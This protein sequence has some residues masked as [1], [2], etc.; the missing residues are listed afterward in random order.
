MSFQPIIPTSGLVGWKFLERTQEAQL[1]AFSNS[2]AVVT[3]TKYFE[4][5]IGKVN[6]PED[7]V[8][9]RRLLR[10]ALG[11]FG[12]EDDINNKFFIKKILEDG[13]LKTDA[14]ANKLSDS[15]YKELT[16]AFGFDLGTPRSKLSDFGSKITA[17]Y[18]QMQFEVAVGEQDD[19]MRMA[20]NASRTLPELVA[21]EGSETTK[22]FQIM[23][24]PP[25][26][27]VFETA[28]GL[29]DAFAQLDLDKQ[30]EVFQDRASSQLGIERLS[31]LSDPDTM[32]KLVQRYLLRSQ[33]E[34]YQS[35]VSSGSIALMLLQG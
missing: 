2:T 20:M 5:N 7:L 13:S 3:D 30:L 27:S 19:S 35:S 8:A 31:D 14:L 21:K 22:W 15:R 18:R 23:G 9:D 24:S 25:L 28:L 17:Q 10:V 33:I 11:A 6:T 12:L 26:R 4:E 34:S 1:Q 29:P 16:V 32:D